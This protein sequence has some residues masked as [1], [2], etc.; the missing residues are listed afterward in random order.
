MFSLN[1]FSNHSSLDKKLSHKLLEAYFKNREKAEGK[2]P[3]SIKNYVEQFLE[4]QD[5]KV[6]KLILKKNLVAVLDL[7][8]KSI[9]I[10]KKAIPELL[11]MFHNIYH[12]LN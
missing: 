1:S 10:A 3:D 8:G 4:L 5:I 6:C 12:H 2:V 7:P 11:A 9:K